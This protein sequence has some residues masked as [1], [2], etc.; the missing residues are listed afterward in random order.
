MIKR[1]EEN[2]NQITLWAKEVAAKVD[3]IDFSEQVKDEILRALQTCDSALCKE[4]EP[5]E[6]VFPIIIMDAV[7]IVRLAGQLPYYLSRAVACW[8]AEKYKMPVTSE[9]VSKECGITYEVQFI[10]EVSNLCSAIINKEE[11]IE[12]VERVNL[13]KKAYEAGY[14]SEKYYRG[15]AQCTLDALY[16]SVGNCDKTLFR[17]TTVFASGMGLFG[18]GPCGGYS[19]GLLYLGGYV[20]RRLEYIDGDKEEK[21]KSWKISELLHK[22]FIETYGTIVCHGIHN[23]IFGKEFHIRNAEDKQA[24][25]AA[26][27]HMMDKCPVVVGTAAMWV[28]EIL[29][30]EGYITADVQEK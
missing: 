25:E 14:Y 18:D 16:K 28:V 3:I 21:D 17:R 20:G 29:L 10:K 4:G 23:K 7:K 11:I 26:G 22:K 9:Q 1:V 30:D 19:A 12:S 8:F 2:I 24:F 27:A 13:K 6:S 5:S 15:C